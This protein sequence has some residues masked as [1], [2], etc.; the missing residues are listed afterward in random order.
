MNIKQ[1][2]QEAF[3]HGLVEGF[4]YRETQNSDNLVEYEF[5]TGAYDYV[6]SFEF[7]GKYGWEMIFGVKTDDGI[8]TRMITSKPDEVIKIL[9]T[10][11]GDILKEF[12]EYSFKFE[13]TLDIIL[14]PQL[15]EGEPLNLDPFQRKR[16]KLYVRTIKKF[17][18]TLPFWKQLKVD[19][20][21]SSFEPKSIIMH[22]EKE[23]P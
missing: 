2:I 21:L 14:A 18:D 1:S 13:G 9:N 11:F 16:G 7:T 19:F 6:V 3:A 12:V 20:T 5:S 23:T 17:V 22:I 10:I 4:S 15:M 8:D